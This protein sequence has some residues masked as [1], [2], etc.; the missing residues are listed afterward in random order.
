M[1]V[2]RSLHRHNVP[3]HTTHMAE[4]LPIISN[5]IIENYSRGPNIPPIL[6]VGLPQDYYPAEKR[7]NSQRLYPSDDA[8]PPDSY[9]DENSNNLQRLLSPWDGEIPQDYYPDEKQDDDHRLSAPYDDVIPQDGYGEFLPE[10]YPY[11]TRQEEEQQQTF[12]KPTTISSPATGT[13]RSNFP[14][15]YIPSYY[16]GNSF[17]VVT[18]S[19][20]PTPP[21][22]PPPPAKCIPHYEYLSDEDPS[23]ENPSYEDRSADDECARD[24]DE[25]EWKEEGWGEQEWEEQEY[26][27][28]EETEREE[29]DGQRRDQTDHQDPRIVSDVSTLSCHSEPETQRWRPVSFVSAVSSSYSGDIESRTPTPEPE[30][31]PVK[32]WGNDRYPPLRLVDDT[33]EKYN[34][35]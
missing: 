33:R 4:Q 29:Q 25:G 27:E 2:A 21:P 19:R 31:R 24:V 20:P 16:G 26:T 14:I 17:N 34:W 9:P 1:V 7:G 13:G 32:L 8:I 3:S 35:L 22:P 12:H 15:S 11:T 6:S 23:Y 5:H 10:Y 28:W 18:P 30:V